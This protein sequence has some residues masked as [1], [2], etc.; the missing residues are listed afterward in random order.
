MEFSLGFPRVM[1][2]EQWSA[3][4]AAISLEIAL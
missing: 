1:P 4:A 3:L 2:P